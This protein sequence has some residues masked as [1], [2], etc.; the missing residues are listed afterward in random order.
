MSLTDLPSLEELTE[1]RDALEEGKDAAY[2][3]YS[4]ELYKAVKKF[5]KNRKK[6]FTR[7]WDGFAY[8]GHGIDDNLHNLHYAFFA[9]KISKDEFL[10]SIENFVL[11]ICFRQVVDAGLC[12]NSD[13]SA[14]YDYLVYK[15]YYAFD[16]E[17]YI[18]FMTKDTSL[19]P[20]DKMTSRIYVKAVES[21]Y[22]TDKR[23]NFIKYKYEE[24]AVMIERCFDV[25]NFYKGTNYS[26]T[27]EGINTFMADIE[28]EKSLAERLEDTIIDQAIKRESAFDTFPKHYAYERAYLSLFKY[29]TGVIKQILLGYMYCYN[30]F[31]LT[32]DEFMFNLKDYMIDE[33]I[34][35]DDLPHYNKDLDCFV[36]DN[37]CVM[38]FTEHTFLISPA[39]KGVY[40]KFG[41]KLNPRL[42]F[43]SDKE[44]VV[45][46]KLYAKYL[47]VH[48]K[49]HMIKKGDVNCRY[50][51]Y[52]GF[53]AFVLLAENAHKKVLNGEV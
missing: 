48:R 36:D 18:D 47:S 2:E 41:A 25:L 49:L 26:M 1:L 12:A 46:S 21:E 13:M 9:K 43:F 11:S 19:K 31:G 35:I 27:P 8:V 24:Y 38:K 22:L 44:K 10:T 45:I 39:E 17:D 51:E 3:K 42:K 30:D 52:T 29:N 20:F 4:D 34:N 28:K 7:K 53:K 32:Y 33:K 37:D 40:E 5:Y 14:W 6:N 23:H 15:Y 50:L 16:K